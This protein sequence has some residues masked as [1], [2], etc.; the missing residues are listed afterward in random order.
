MQTFSP[1]LAMNEETL[2]VVKPPYQILEPISVGW[3]PEET[4]HGYAIIWDLCQEALIRDELEWILARPRGVGLVIVLPPAEAARV[5]LDARVALAALAAALVMGV[6]M[7]APIAWH[8]L[9]SHGAMALGAES[10]ATTMHRTTERLRHVFLVAQIALAFVLL[11]GAGLLTVSLHRVMSTA[12]GFQPDGVVSALAV[13]TVKGYP[14]RTARMGLAERL[15]E[16]EVELIDHNG[17]PRGEKYFVF[18]NPP[19]VN[20]QLGIRRS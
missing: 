7:G 4:A 20:K 16:E 12:R 8:S 15:L 19:V 6:A 18:Y 14:S 3:A 2:H 13:M 5:T 9:R 1:E 11:S 17:A 10:R